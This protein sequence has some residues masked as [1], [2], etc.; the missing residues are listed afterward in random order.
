[1]K[2]LIHLSALALLIGAL[3]AT[4]AAAATWYILPDGTGDAPTI[5]AGLDA[6]AEND[7]VLVAAGTFYENLTWPYTQGLVLTSE[8]G[9]EATIIDGNDA[10]RVILLN[11][12]LDASTTISYLTIRNGYLA[13][14]VFDGS[15][16]G[17]ACYQNASPTIMGNV[18]TAN[19]NRGNYVVGA[20]IGCSS[21]SA[22]IIEN[23]IT[24]NT[25]ENGNVVAGA[26]IFCNY[27]P[28]TI[29]G[30]TIAYNTIDTTATYAGGGGIYFDE[31]SPLIAENTIMYNDGNEVGGGISWGLDSTPIVRDNII[32]QNHSDIRGGGIYVRFQ[33]GA[34]GT[35]TGNTIANNTSAIG[36]GICLRSNLVTI[37][38]NLITENAA[39]EKGGGIYCTDT[40]AVASAGS[41]KINNNEITSNTSPS[42]TGGGI[43][44]DGASPLIERCNIQD[45][46]IGIYCKTLDGEVSDPLIRRNA[47]HEN[48]DF[49]LVNA[50]DGL[51]VD[52]ILNWWGHT[53]GPFNADQNPGGLGDAVSDYVAFD[54]WLTTVGVEPGAVPPVVVHLGNHP[55]PFNPQTKITFTLGEP[56]RAEIAVYDLNGQLVDVLAN[57]I[58]EAGDHSV[59]WDGKDDLARV[60]PSGTY[61]VR[62]S[63][64]S[65]TQARKVMLLR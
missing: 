58:Y 46:G 63:T 48:L 10:G 13:A 24:H 22:M 30:N 57:R 59:V 3:M 56:Q 47:I 27:Q 62:L 34:A 4:P 20:G 61:V 41:A 33:E 8:S 21:S 39:S 38:D 32:E 36:A 45:N 49:G 12:P 26:G 19:T 51:T 42:G 53:S 35:V 44:L 23:T 2:H 54:P 50:D 64:V 31:C 28:A 29:V 60:V 37:S 6:C 55:N 17:I 18:I 9:P 25:I 52:A 5:Q 7:T 65:A 43:H 40:D 14:D 16:A 11:V 1:M 15:G